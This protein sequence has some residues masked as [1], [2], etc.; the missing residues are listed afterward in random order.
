M[1]YEM[2]LKIVKDNSPEIVA[3]MMV[4]LREVISGLSNGDYALLGEGWRDA[5]KEYPKGQGENYLIYDGDEMYTAWP[6]SHSRHG[7]RDL[8]SGIEIEGVIA[9]MPLSEIGKPAFA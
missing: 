3:S 7:W 2:A 6:D 4:E 9:W 1:D 5:R 8:I